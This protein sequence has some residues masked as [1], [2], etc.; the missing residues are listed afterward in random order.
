MEKLGKSLPEGWRRVPCPNGSKFYYIT[1]PPP[2]KIVLKS[3][4]ENYHKKG[5]YLEMPV[6]ELDFGTK[7]RNKKYS[8][9]ESL[10]TKTDMEVDGRY[11]VDKDDLEASYDENEGAFMNNYVDESEVSAGGAMNV[12]LEENNN[13]EEDGSRETANEEVKTKRDVKLENE[14]RRMENAVEKLTLN[15]D[16]KVDH[17]GNLA[18][19]AKILNESRKSNGGGDIETFD[20]VSFKSSLLASQNIEQVLRSLKTCPQLQF[21][22]TNLEQSKLLEQLLNMSRL[23]D[24]PLSSF[25]FD[26]NNNH[27]CDIIDFG[28]KHSPDVISLILKLSI[29]NEDP[30]NENDVIRIAYLLS[31]LASAVSGQNN[32]LKKIKSISSKNNGLTNAGLDDLAKMGIFETS[33]SWRNDRD[34]LAGL[35]DEILKRNARIFVSQVTFDNLDMNIAN[36][37]H[38]MTLPFLEF[39]TV[40]TSNLSK[41]GKSVEEALEFF[42]IETVDIMSD[43]NKDLFDHLKNV[44]AWNLGRLFG[45]E[46]EGFSWLLQVFPNHYEHPNSGNAGNKSHIFTQKPL[47]YSENSNADMIHIMEVLQRQYLNLVGEQLENKEAYMKD[48]QLIYNADIDEVA[49]VEAEERVKTVVTE[50]GD[51]ICHGDLLTEVRFEACKRLRRMCVSAVERFDF[52]KIFRLGTFHLHMNKIL[53]DIV[54]GMKSE[55]N[56]EDT[57]SLGY[58]KTILGLNHI[59]NQPDV[60]KKDG[61]YEAHFQ[62]CE[63]IGQEFLIEAFKEYVKISEPNIVRTKEKAKDLLLSF[64]DTTGIQYHYNPDKTDDNQEAFDD[65]LTSCKDIASRTLVSMVLKSVEHEADG[66]GLRAVRTVMIPYF[67]NRKEEVQD[68]K[69]AARLLFNKVAFLQASPRTKARIDNLACCNPSGKLGRSIARDQQNEHKIKTTKVLLKGLHSQ[70][71]DLTVEKTTVGSNILEI[72]ENHD[73]LAMMMSEEGGKSSHRYLTDSQKQKIRQEIIRVKPFNINR[74]KVEYYDKP[75]GA[76]SGM[77]VEKLE[78]FL[79]RNK[80]NFKRNSPH[81]S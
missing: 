62:F 43:F 54:S 2:V 9:V 24:N 30:V 77:T 35:S 20:F 8:V 1:R 72:V 14:R 36:V 60:I 32:A 71:T 61:N 76:F 3:Q 16:K 44:V 25:P 33:R 39:E 38:H 48:L 52:M 65:I 57:L 63:D 64:L 7:V 78:R 15:P 50:A 5:K 67:L 27:Y 81:R 29:K 11:E 19:S 59:T 4:L 22:I 21:K 45:K 6:H 10:T 75:R 46:V 74:E 47:N 42:K 51:M 49:R 18:Q 31:S 56:V 41:E 58:F 13:V 23:P 69:Y 17:R 28:L 66:L 12:Y 70:L 26:I 37:M 73:R 55:V 34:L 40:D 80:G 79:V 68:S 53:M